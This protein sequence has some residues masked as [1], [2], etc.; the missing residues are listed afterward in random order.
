MLND[1]AEPVGSTP[2]AFQKH[3]A[4]EMAKW[5]GVVKRAHVKVE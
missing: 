1:G 2:A 4:S 3:M 5:R